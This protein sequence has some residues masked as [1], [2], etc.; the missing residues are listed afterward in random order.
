MADILNFD[1]IP[2]VVRAEATLNILAYMPNNEMTEDDPPV[3]KYTDL[4]WFNEIVWRHLKSINKRGHNIR[5][6]LAAAEAVDIE[7][8]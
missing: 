4:E 3:P 7:N 8:P 5:V 2:I 1:A 6:D